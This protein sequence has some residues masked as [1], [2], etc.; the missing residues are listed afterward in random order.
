MPPSRPAYAE[1]IAPDKEISEFFEPHERQSGRGQVRNHILRG[2]PREELERV[3]AAA[4]LVPLRPRQV[5]V[6]PNL[7]VMYGYFI[8][9]GVAS[10]L[11]SCGARKPMEVCLVGNRG[12]VGIPLVLGTGRSPLRCMVQIKGTA[13]RLPATDFEILLKE[14]AFL[15]R[16][17]FA[18]IQGRLHQEALLNVCNASHSVPERICRWLLMAHDRLQSDHIPA[19]HDLIARM[20]GVRRPGVTDV[21][22]G[23]EKKGIIHLARGSIEIKQMRTLER[24]ACR[25]LQ[26]I[27]SE[28]E[29]LH[30]CTAG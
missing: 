14:C 19:T 4:E 17:L 26:R 29:R 10:V 7:S 20:L 16:I 1:A 21:L 6:E 24:S 18:N 22:G 13:W 15:Q 8:E 28:F 2:L 11:A 3:L 23:L 12:F 5:L 30:S 27:D 9:S 25:C